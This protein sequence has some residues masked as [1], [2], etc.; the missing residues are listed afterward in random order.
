[1]RI[2]R[3]EKVEIMKGFKD[4]RLSRIHPE[5]LAFI[6]LKFGEIDL[7]EWSI[8]ADTM[9]FNSQIK[10]NDSQLMFKI[11][12]PSDWSNLDSAESDLIRLMDLE[13]DNI[14]VACSIW[15]D[16]GFIT[17]TRDRKIVSLD[18]LE[19]FIDRQFKILNDAC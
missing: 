1:M 3:L 14:R 9:I 12:I 13:V 8:G 17:N 5:F 19:E 4:D 11:V 15:K 6:N 18:D 16:G 10:L 7:W 2:S